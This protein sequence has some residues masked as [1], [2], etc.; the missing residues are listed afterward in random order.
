MYSIFKKEIHSFFSSLIGYIVVMVFLTCIGIFMWV[1]ADTSVLNFNYATLDQL[2]S[3]GPLVYLFLIP[4]ITMRSFAEEKNKG[5]IE[6][7]LTKPLT[8]TD[9][10]GGKFLANVTLV[11][12]SLLHTLIYYYSVYQL[13]SPK[14][15]LD[16]GAITGSYIGLLFLGISFVAMGMFASSVSNNQITAFILG[17][18]LCFL[19]H[20]SFTY[21][22]RMPAF[23]GNIDLLI[24]KIGIN[25][26]YSAL[27][28]GAIDSRDILYF[29]SLSGLFL[30][31]TNNALQKRS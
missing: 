7:L 30:L 21:V 19:F 17:A 12:F 25:Y 1:F 3:I 16:A 20:W 13:G 10:I 9:V 29:L 28:K 15:N 14:G 11:V 2:F 4:A 5:T 22:S 23:N 27:S 26:H 24:Q 18:F 6:F 8:L 31:F